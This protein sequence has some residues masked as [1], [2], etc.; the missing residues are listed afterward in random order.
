MKKTLMNSIIIYIIVSGIMG[1]YLYVFGD[2]EVYKNLSI[3]TRIKY[4]IQ[5]LIVSF[6]Y[7]IIS[8]K[9][10]QIISKDIKFVAIG[11]FIISIVFSIII[12]KGNWVWIFSSLCTIGANPA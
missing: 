5:G 11:S 1:T 4:D 12:M 9:L 7:T 10:P 6:L 8:I 2:S 3:I